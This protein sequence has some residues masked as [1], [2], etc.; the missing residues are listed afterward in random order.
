MSIPCCISCWPR[1][2][3]KPPDPRRLSEE[4]I[5]R[6]IRLKSQPEHNLPHLIAG[7]GDD[8]AGFLPENHPLLVST[9]MLVEGVHFDM[10]YMTPYDLGFKAMAANLSDLA[11][12]GA[13]P[14]YGFL[15]LGLSSPEADFLDQLM[16]GMLT[17][18]RQHGLNLIGGDTVR[19]PL[20]VINL[21]VMGYGRASQLPLRAKAQVGDAVCVTGWLGLSSGGLKYL[22]QKEPILKPEAKTLIKAH[23]QPQPRLAAGQALAQSGRLH[24]MM[25]ISDGLATDLARICQASEVGAIIEEALLP[26]SPETFSLAAY[27]GDSAIDWALTGGEDYELLFTCR[28]QD[29]DTLKQL[30]EK[31]APGLSLCQVG[32]ISQTRQLLLRQG[33]GQTVS[34][35]FK[36]FD[37]FKE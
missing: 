21:C 6:L 22:Q 32:A 29:V 26:I 16:E 17:L 13:D 12:M 25:D 2:N 9:D 28:P 4:D 3:G 36:G 23:L 20:I 11:A 35:L 5:V 8:A 7:I 33:S 19:S 31:A 14:A 27:L 37:H 34:I 1:M 24:A 10:S 15:S 18:S 30:V